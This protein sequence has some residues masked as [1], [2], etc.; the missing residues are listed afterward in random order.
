MTT[1]RIFWLFGYSGAGKTTL[2]HGL[3][4]ELRAAGR[5]VLV[6]DGDEVRAGLNRDLGFSEESRAENIRRVAEVAKL[7]ADQGCIVIAALITPMERLRQL[8]ADV[9]GRDRFDLV[10]VDVPLAVCQQRDA[11]GLYQRAASGNMPLLTGV[12]APFEPAK[13]CALHLQTDSRENLLA[14]FREFVRSRIK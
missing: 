3:A 14:A 10:W 8:A 1:G 13:S 2:A 12:G 9:G 11:K 4:A 6:L 7:A 5:Q